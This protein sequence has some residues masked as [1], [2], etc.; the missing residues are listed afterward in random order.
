MTDQ[1]FLEMLSP[2][3]DID[4]R[5]AWNQSLMEF[6]QLLAEVLADIGREARENNVCRYH[7]S[8]S[9]Q[10]QLS[11]HAVLNNSVD[12]VANGNGSAG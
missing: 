9:D 4:V 7:R 6:N 5:D 8:H 11:G 3:T 12:T 10:R 1:E 2:K